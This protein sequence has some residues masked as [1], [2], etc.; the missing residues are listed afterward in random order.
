MKMYKV[1]R[2]EKGWSN[3]RIQCEGIADDGMQISND[4]NKLQAWAEAVSFRWLLRD[5]DAVSEGNCCC[6]ISDKRFFFNLQIVF[7][8]TLWWTW[9]CCWYMRCTVSGHKILSQDYTLITTTTQKQI[10]TRSSPPPLSYLLLLFF[11]S[12]LSR[13]LNIL[14]KWKYNPWKERRMWERWLLLS[15]LSSSLSSFLFLLFCLALS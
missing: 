10:D 13:L 15:S 8:I 1:L 7:F 2:L 9:S 3:P 12:H 11:H 5:G 14:S 4:G 6:K